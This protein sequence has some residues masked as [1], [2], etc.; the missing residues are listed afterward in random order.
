M[1]GEIIHDDENIIGYSWDIA[2]EVR[3]EMENMDEDDRELFQ[4]LV[5]QL[6]E[7]DGLVFVSYHP[8]GAY[9]VED[10]ITRTE[11]EGK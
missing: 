3:E 7:H 4:D 8:M 6:E 11:A 5:D 2:D 10:L 1:R 9:I